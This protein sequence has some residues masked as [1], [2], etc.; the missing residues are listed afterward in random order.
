[1]L[2]N[3][4]SAK[5]PEFMRYK[6]A[7]LT[8]DVKLGEV[9]RNVSEQLA[10]VEEAA[11]NG[12]KLI[13]TPEM[14]TTG[15]CWYNRAEVKPYVETIPGPTTDRFQ[16]IAEKY[17]CYIIVGMPEVD[18]KTDIYYNSAAFIGPKGI[19]GV[20]RK[21]HQYIAEPKWSKEGDYDFQVWETPIGNIGICICMDIHF[22]ETARMEGLRGADVIVHISNWLAEKTPAP[23]WLTRAYDNGVYVLE[24]NRIGLERT[25]E[26]AGG[27]VLIN[28]DGTIDSY[29]DTNPLMYGEVDIAKA[30][31]KKFAN[32]GNKMLERR[33]EEYMDI[34]HNTYL[35]NPLDFHSLYGYDPLPEGKKSNVSVAQVNAVKGDVAKNIQ[36]IEERTAEAA[37]TG[38][39]LIVFPELMMTGLVNADTAK[40]LAQTSK[41]D[42]VNKL[43][44]ISM[45]Y[46]IYIVAG[47]IEKDGES[48]YNTAVLTGPEGLAGKYRK[49]HLNEI[50]AGWAACGNLGFPHFNT[51][52]GRIGILIGHDAEFPECGRLLALQG[53]DLICFPSAMNAPKPFGLAGTNN[54]HNYPIPMGYSTIHWH[55][56]RVRGGE[57][58][59]YALFANMTSDYVVGDKCFGR[60]GIFHPDTFLFPR[61]EK[62]LGAEE[63]GVVTITIDNSNQPGSVYPTNVVRRKDIV[64]MRHP[65]MYDVI[66]DK[67]APVYDFFK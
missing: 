2:I 55:L 36:I 41:G 51:P 10:L 47:M 17:D 65:I 6:V 35:W 62:I 57:N 23:Y 21:N 43:I 22:I 11:K 52:V 64:C 27:S 38:S 24:S 13:A 16:A 33:P 63:E 66:V 49:M 53:C 5:K 59:V 37:N 67:N 48:L 44:D 26:F 15:Y 4:G 20:H 45:K 54:W 50:D 56:W 60:S 19:V 3:V 28:P 30:R 18:P 58:N 40:D 25:V 29:E 61:N 8:V 46:H 14:S 42:F 1:M 12:A 31:S 32:G 34:M 39:E 9:E 7:A